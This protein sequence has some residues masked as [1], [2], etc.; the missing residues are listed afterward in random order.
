MDLKLMSILLSMLSMVTPASVSLQREQRHR[1]PHHFDRGYQLPSEEEYKS[2]RNCHTISF[3]VKLSPPGCEPRIVYNNYC[4]GFCTSFFVPAQGS[5]IPKEESCLVCKP[6]A[7]GTHT[8]TISL[9]CLEPEPNGNQMI[10]VLKPFV[11]SIVDQCECGSCT[12]ND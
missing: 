4:K 2:S 6:A 5:S 12:R 1:S 7:N 8:Q 11:M 9:Q 10:K 3:E